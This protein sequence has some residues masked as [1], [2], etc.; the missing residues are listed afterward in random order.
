MRGY[1]SDITI[2]L[3]WVFIVSLLGLDLLEGVHTE[4]VIKVTLLSHLVQANH[5][6]DVAHSEASVCSQDREKSNRDASCP[7]Y[8]TDC[9][10]WLPHQLSCILRVDETCLSIKE[11]N[12]DRTPKALH[13]EDEECLLWVIHLVAEEQLGSQTVEEGAKEAD[14]DGVP[15]LDG[16]TGGRNSHCAW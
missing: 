16:I 11:S 10:Y 4:Q 9:T 8:Q 6:V 13:S 2:P 3:L 12:R 7:D 14:N 15:D 1:L 5:L